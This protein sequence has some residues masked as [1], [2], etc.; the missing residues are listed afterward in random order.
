MKFEFWDFSKKFRPEHLAETIGRHSC[1]ESEGKLI[2]PSG[3]LDLSADLLNSFNNIEQAEESHDTVFYPNVQAGW[4][5]VNLE[6]ILSTLFS[7]ISIL[8]AAFC[9]FIGS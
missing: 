2:E 1:E 9:V 8:T 3:T 4:S 6:V 5:N 7:Q